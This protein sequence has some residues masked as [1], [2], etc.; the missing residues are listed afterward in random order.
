MNANCRNYFLL[1]NLNDTELLLNNG[2][3]TRLFSVV[4][5]HNFNYIL[6]NRRGDSSFEP[7]H[8]MACANIL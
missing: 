6:G 3:V 8:F 2:F 5:H 1:E 4:T 7:I